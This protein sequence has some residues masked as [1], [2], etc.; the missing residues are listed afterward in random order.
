MIIIKFS[1]KLV[2]GELRSN[3]DP[4]TC[5][6]DLFECDKRMAIHLAQVKFDNLE[7]DF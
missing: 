7:I 1:W 5:K 3:N 6:R 4:G 2:D